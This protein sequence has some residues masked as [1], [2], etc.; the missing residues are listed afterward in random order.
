MYASV[1]THVCVHGCIYGPEARRSH[2]LIMQM[3]MDMHSNTYTPQMCTGMH[4][5]TYTP[6]CTCVQMHLRC[7]GTCV[8]VCVC[9]YHVNVGGCNVHRD[10]AR[11]QVR[12]SKASEG[13]GKLK[14]ERER[15]R[16]RERRRER[17]GER[18]REREKESERERK[19]ERVRTFKKKHA[20]CTQGLRTICPSIPSHP[21]AI[22]GSSLSGNTTHDPGNVQAESPSA[23]VVLLRIFVPQSQ[24]PVA[25]VYTA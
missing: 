24:P 10:S 15:E 8:C 6:P 19:R 18:G 9:V 13:K 11:M 22:T 12:E 14:G 4:A 25:A 20:I 3:C 7:C 2:H 1:C 17:E 16:E 23:C 21:A 5:L